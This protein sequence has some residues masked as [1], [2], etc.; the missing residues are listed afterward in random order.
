MSCDLHAGSPEQIALARV[1]TSTLSLT[2]RPLQRFLEALR[3]IE[4]L[5]FMI[6]LHPLKYCRPRTKLLVGQRLGVSGEARPDSE[7]FLEAVAEQR[8]NLARFH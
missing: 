1:E 6:G 4:Q 7:K 5:S 3:L 2:L 8:R